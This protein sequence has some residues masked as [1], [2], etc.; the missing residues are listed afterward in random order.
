MNNFKR[1][2]ERK[3][4]QSQYNNFGIDN[5]DENRFGKFPSENEIQIS[6]IYK[7]KRLLKKIIGYRNE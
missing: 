4:I 6:K 7:I 3:L 1:A 5:Y 2:L